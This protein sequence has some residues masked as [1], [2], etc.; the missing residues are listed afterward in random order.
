VS[1]TPTTPKG[2]RTRQSIVEAGRRVFAR[3]GF[4]NARMSDIAEE[5]QLSLGGLYRYFMNKDDVFEAVIAHVHEDLFAASSAAD[6]NFET[7]PYEALLE[8]NRGYLEH[9]WEHRDVMRAFMEAAHVDPRFRDIWWTMRTRHVARF[10][11][12]L[13]RSGESTTGINPR[14]AA[15][16]MAC[17]VEQAA[18]VWFAQEELYG[19][20]VKRH[21][22]ADVVTWAWYRTFFDD[23]PAR[24]R[25]A[26]RGA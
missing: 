7:E 8:A 18:Y 25:V 24:A 16:A 14:L 1:A 10:L 6:H 3:D 12:A 21:E 20:E 9:Y 5:S 17:M 13:E 23:A 2:R 4:V 15:E 19:Q 26:G 11:K 22:A